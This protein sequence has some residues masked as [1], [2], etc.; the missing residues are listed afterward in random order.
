L[1]KRFWSGSSELFVGIAYG[2]TDLTEVVKRLVGQ[3]LY[4]Q[5]RG[6]TDVQEDDGT[7]GRLIK[8]VT[9]SFGK[10]P[11][12][13]SDVEDILVTFAKCCNPLPG[14]PVIGFITRGR[15]LTIHTANCSRVLASDPERKLEVSWDT[16]QKTLR[17][18][19]IKVVC[20]DK[21][22]MLSSISQRISAQGVNISQ[23]H[24]A[25]TTDKRAVNTFEVSISSAEQLTSLMKALEKIKGV[26][27]VERVRT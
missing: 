1:A 18:A 11:I 8:R 9:K 27:T 25:T 3:E 4:E 14:D 16:K 17:R 13:I 19:K 6:K 5:V 10:S 21:P 20:T 22:G 24:V 2:K 26:V 7:F 12:K 23:A 15:G